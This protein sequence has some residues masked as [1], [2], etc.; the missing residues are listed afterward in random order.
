M[1]DKYNQI[2]QTWKIKS[3]LNEAANDWKQS[4]GCYPTIGEF[5]Q[6]INGFLDH[7]L[8]QIN[9]SA[10]EQFISDKLINLYT[11]KIVVLMEDIT[12]AELRWKMIEQQTKSQAKQNEPRPGGVDWRNKQK[13][14][15]LERKKPIEL[16]PLEDLSPEKEPKVAVP[17]RTPNV[18]S[19]PK[20]S[21]VPT[22]SNS[23]KTSSSFR[24]R[25]ARYAAPVLNSVAAKE[26]ANFLVPDAVGES[27][28]KA[29]AA[30]IQQGVFFGGSSM[31]AA[32]GAAGQAI[33]GDLGSFVGGFAGHAIKPPTV[34]QNAVN[35]TGK[36]VDRA[37]KAAPIVG[38]IGNVIKTVSPW[39][40]GASLL[41]SM[42]TTANA[43]QNNDA[44]SAGLAAASVVP[45]PAISI[46]AIAVQA[47]MAANPNVDTAVRTTVR[48]ALPPSL[49]DYA[50][51]SAT[52][53][54]DE[55]SK[56][57][58]DEY[59]AATKRM[60][61]S[62]ENKAIGG[63][64]PALAGNPIPDADIVA[65]YRAKVEAETAKGVEERKKKNSKDET[66][67][68]FPNTNPQTGEQVV[69]ESF[70]NFLKKSRLNEQ[71]IPALV[72]VAAK[73]LPE[74]ETLIPKVLPKVENILPKWLVPKAVPKKIID[75]S[76]SS[77]KPDA[78]LRAE[79]ELA[80]KAA[81]AA[82]S[83]GKSTKAIP[84]PTKTDN[85]QIND[86]I[87]WAMNK[88]YGGQN[89]EE[90]QKTIAAQQAKQTADRLAAEKIKHDSEMTPAKTTV[91]PVE[92]TSMEDA[93]SAKL[94]GMRER[95]QEKLKDVAAPAPTPAPTAE[96]EENSAPEPEEEE[97]PEPEE[98]DEDRPIYPPITPPVL[99][100]IPPIPPIRPKPPENTPVDPNEKLPPVGSGDSTGEAS[101][102][103]SVRDET[104]PTERY[105]AMV[106]RAERDKN[107]SKYTDYISTVNES[108]SGT[109]NTRSAVQ[110][111]A[112]KQQYKIVV[113]QDGKKLEIFAKSIQGIRRAV[114]GKKS[115]RVY[116]GKG[117]DI[118]NY[119]KRLMASK[120]ST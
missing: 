86:I 113:V 67:G 28:K 24:S 88:W 115:Y 102:D 12:D 100:P 68:E 89:V 97:K 70:Y 54:Q 53:Q 16:A 61:T 44:V 108:R 63:P 48:N 3:I 73:V 93:E 52:E 118:T 92:D 55:L 27:T 91:T 85:G 21:E 74:V 112:K 58:T 107:T 34:I 57:E 29:I 51:K 7:D 72:K 35:T 69:F 81:E 49:K 47:G 109:L 98:K 19:E 59:I 77:V 56:R 13:E 33:G 110:N 36:L 103:S 46:P 31:A 37:V 8:F 117:S 40:G 10:D 99:I 64:G 38:K 95:V 111:R 17:E 65:K 11:H 114:F 25:A 42:A 20:T 14:L 23:S 9:E 104:A 80:A 87:Q 41:G 18:V 26:A 66:S 106:A 84:V 1:S 75:V 39:I 5:E 83:T 96:P 105:S 78:V 2:K 15:E 94:R 79:N 6:I 101:P 50:G 119:F 4:Y 22:S 43:A 60:G 71:F 120:K 116:D 82:E 45:N 32:G 90:M 30:G 62:K 76:P